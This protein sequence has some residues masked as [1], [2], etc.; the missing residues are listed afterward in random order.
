VATAGG[1]TA[2]GGTAAAGAD[3]PEILIIEDEPGI[4]DFLVPGLGYEG[5][6]TRVARDGQTG[7]RMALEREPD[8]VVLDLML[9]GMDGFA[10]C[11]CLRERSDVPVIMLT[12]RDD[13]RDRVRG[14][15]TGADDYVTKP[16][17]FKE[18]AAR[19]R[20]VLR[21][22][23][24]QVTGSA[25]GSAGTLHLQDITLDLDLR[26]ARRAGRD[27][28]LT[29]REFELLEILMR[30]PDRVLS[31][32]TILDR[33]WG[34]DFLGDDNI[35]EV[36]VRYLRQKLGEPNPITTVR[37]TGYVMRTRPPAPDG[38]APA[39]AR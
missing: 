35:I 16:F 6:A 27:I 31:R 20:A 14:L 36:Y 4:V 5:F 11:R 23:R 10:V 19:I 22:R 13:L 9:P 7:L 1:T 29:R 26:L 3:R 33:V 32:A 18:L 25:P 12:A 37:G 2:A 30:N 8:L 21:R 38:G 28:S 17:H 15:E 34:Q 39:G 24:A